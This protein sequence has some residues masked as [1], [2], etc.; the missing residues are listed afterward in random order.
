MLRIGKRGGNFPGMLAERTFHVVWVAP[1]HGTGIPV[2]TKPDVIV[3]Y[4]GSA[5]RV[6]RAK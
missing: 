5:V 4:S 1:D 6:V 3:R 2:T